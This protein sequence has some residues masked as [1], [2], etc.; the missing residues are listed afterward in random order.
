LIIFTLYLIHPEKFER[1]GIHALK[2]LA[3]RSFIQRSLFEE[4]VKIIMLRNLLVHR[5]GII[6]DKII[7][8]AVKK[9]FKY[10]EEF[11]ERVFLFVRSIWRE[12]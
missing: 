3:D 4:L 1:I 2:L 7:Y 10:V 5:Y 11:I 12:I 6:D 9:N 8:D